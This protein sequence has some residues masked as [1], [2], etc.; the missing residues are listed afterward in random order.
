MD[1]FDQALGAL[2]NAV[3][4]GECVVPTA[5]LAHG[6][7]SAIPANVSRS[8]LQILAACPMNCA[9]STCDVTA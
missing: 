7:C 2:L 4:V 6:Y 8:M 1:E 3:A 5:Q 9:S